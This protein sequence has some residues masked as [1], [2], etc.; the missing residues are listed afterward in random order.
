[1]KMKHRVKGFTLVELVIV[2]ALFSL[3]MFSI[4][5]LLRPV[6][7]FFVR[8]S[9]FENTTARVDNMKRAIEGNLKYANRVRCYVDYLPYTAPHTST[10][11]GDYAPTAT[12]ERHVQNFYDEF[13]GRN[14]SSEAVAQLG[15]AGDTAL[16]QYIDCRGTIYVLV[17]DNRPPTSY[18]AGSLTGFNEGGENTGKIVLYQFPFDNT[19]DTPVEFNAGSAS[20]TVQP[21]YVNQKMYGNFDYQF[22]LNDPNAFDD[23][24]LVS[25]G[26]TPTPPETPETPEAVVFDPGNFAITINMYEI[27]KAGTD[28]PAPDYTMLN[29]VLARN[30]IPKHESVT[31]SMKNVLDMGEGVDHNYST[32]LNEFKVFRDVAHLGYVVSRTEGQEYFQDSAYPIPKYYNAFINGNDYSTARYPEPYT[33]NNFGAGYTPIAASDAAFNGTIDGTTPV[34]GFYFIYTLPDTTYGYINP[35]NPADNY[36]DGGY[37]SQAD[38]AFTTAPSAT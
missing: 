6:S 27:R 38:A 29:D 34:Q 19:G 14:K 21:W 33:G 7:K 9:N 23:A 37:L 18:S 28:T 3:I 4:L 32:P 36:A 15:A 10:D 22:I 20:Y 13:F 30:V 25:E 1:M 31:F 11:P 8:S 17:F 16:R 12:L 5:Q 24:H 2:M 35:N 26:E